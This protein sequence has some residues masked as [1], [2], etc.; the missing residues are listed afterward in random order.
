MLASVHPKTPPRRHLKPNPPGPPVPNFCQKTAAAKV[1]PSTSFEEMYVIDISQDS[2]AVV[3]D[4]RKDA[5]L[6]HTTT[7]R[8]EKDSGFAKGE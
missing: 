3:K 1:R 7:P 4:T 8:S 2:E 5:N 6:P